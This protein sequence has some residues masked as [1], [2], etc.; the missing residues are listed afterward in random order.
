MCTGRRCPQRPLALSV[1]LE[2][3]GLCWAPC[4]SLNRKDPPLVLEEHI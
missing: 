1:G 3:A 2:P 4:T